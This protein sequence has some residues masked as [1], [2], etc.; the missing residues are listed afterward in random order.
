MMQRTHNP[1]SFHLTT[2]T[3]QRL[4]RNSNLP[5]QF[6]VHLSLS[7]SRMTQSFVSSTHLISSQVYSILR[8]MC[9]N[10]YLSL[11][12]MVNGNTWQTDV[13][14]ADKLRFVVVFSLSS[15]CKTI[16]AFLLYFF[17]VLLLIEYKTNNK[18]CRIFSRRA[19]F[20]FVRIE[21]CVVRVHHFY[22][23]H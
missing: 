13:S 3:G 12:K 6:F 8:L 7:R 11:W 17:Q 14:T 2:S 20:P 22:A 21:T 23:A 19:V 4:F 16:H 1:Q 15:E 9:G 5:N 10:Q 18:W